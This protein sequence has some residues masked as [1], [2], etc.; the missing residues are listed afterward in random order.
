[1]A[2]TLDFD[3]IFTAY[4]SQFRADADIPASTDD[5]YTVAMRLANEAINYWARYDGTYWRELFA[6]LQT[7]S[8]GATT[9][10][11]T[12]TKTYAAPTAFA[13][14]G[15]NV[16][17]LDSSNNT[18]ETY[19]ILEPNEV[20]F[21]GDNDIYAYFTRAVTGL[22][23]LH[24]NPAPTANLNGKSIDYVYYKTPT[25]FTTGADTTEMSNPYFIVHRMLANQFR[26][27]RNPYYSS[28]IKDAESALRIMQ[29]ENNAGNWANT[30]TMGDSSGTAWGA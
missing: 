30:P 1:M 7:A 4:Y 21:K 14:A 8:T 3:D 11:T 18:I 19:P 25:L 29:L 26:A 28:A 16:K 17:I 15:G 6:T 9:T 24:L 23:T 12:G 22:Y 10:I 20:Q 5:E 13:A 2:T 27:S